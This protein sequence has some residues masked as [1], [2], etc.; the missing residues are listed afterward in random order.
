MSPGTEIIQKSNRPRKKRDKNREK[1]IE[2][3]KMWVPDSLVI[4]EKNNSSLGTRRKI[5]LL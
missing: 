2:V 4:H 5:P 3:E 1:R